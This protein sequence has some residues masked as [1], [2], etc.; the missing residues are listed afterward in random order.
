MHAMFRDSIKETGLFGGR[1]LGQNPD[2]SI[3]SFPPCYSQS[4]MACLEIS[5]NLHTL[6]TFLKFSYCILYRQMPKVRQWTLT[7]AP[8]F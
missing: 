4:P 3:K 1:I 2:K 6:L 8:F 5:S 7:L